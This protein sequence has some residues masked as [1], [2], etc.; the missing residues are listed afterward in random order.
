MKIIV[1][2]SLPKKKSPINKQQ[3][4]QI[5]EVDEEA[6]NEQKVI[7]VL[8]KIQQPTFIIKTMKGL[9]L[10]TLLYNYFFFNQSGATWEVET[11]SSSQD[12]SKLVSVFIPMILKE[13][14]KEE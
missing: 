8:A 12:K 11:V 14:T 2:S 5:D 7:K 13:A 1:L 6:D 4:R 3:D 10:K 9:L